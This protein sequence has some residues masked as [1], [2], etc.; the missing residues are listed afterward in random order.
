MTDFWKKRPE[1][2]L[3]KSLIKTNNHIYLF[4]LPGI[5][6]T[7]FLNTI[8]DETN[9]RFIRLNGMTCQDKSGLLRTLGNKLEKEFGFS[10]PE[11]VKMNSLIEHLTTMVEHLRHK[12]QF[13][14]NVEQF[15]IV[16]DNAEKMNTLS[17]KYLASLFKIKYLLDIN[18][19]V[20]LISS[21]YDERIDE[22]FF[23]REFELIPKICIKKPSI[24]ELQS[25]IYGFI[26]NNQ[27]FVFLAA[28]PKKMTDFIMDIIHSFYYTI[29]QINQYITIIKNIY[30]VLIE[31]KTI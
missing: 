15:Y 6:K 30:Q 23:L 17:P 3:V 24:E 7:H 4:G 18:F 19:S 22:F 14:F 1:Y 2:E 12:G 16:I 10:L 11:S 31:T 26:E 29:Q 8:L 21:S 5:G 9:I 28:H 13:E 27:D 20:I 25:I